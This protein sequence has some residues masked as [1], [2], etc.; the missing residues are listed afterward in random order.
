V[1]QR[2]EDREGDQHHPGA[3]TGDTSQRVNASTVARSS[4]TRAAC[5]AGFHRS[6]MQLG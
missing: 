6:L 3:V 5:R 1:P 4:L 2:E